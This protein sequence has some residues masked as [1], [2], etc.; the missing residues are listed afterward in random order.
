M[1]F[2]DAVAAVME[3]KITESVSVAGILKTELLRPSV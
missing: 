3:G 2:V 1:P